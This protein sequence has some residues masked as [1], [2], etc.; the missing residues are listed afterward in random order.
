MNENDSQTGDGRCGAKTRAGTPCKRGAG[1]GTEHVGIGCCKLHG[2]STPNH[3]KSAQNQRALE[4]VQKYAIPIKTD[5][6]EAL[7]FELE[8]TAGWVAFLNEQVQGIE[9]IGHMRQLKGGGKDG[10]PEEVPH[11]WIQML[12]DERSHLLN[13]AK[14]C[15]AVGIEERRVK[16]AEQQGELLADFVRGLLEDL[17]IPITDEVRKVV[18]NRL[19]LIQGGRA[20]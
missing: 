1:A 20:A 19:T 10:I 18:R 13:V 8:R 6:H 4:A 9:K 5:P 2:G 3:I 12:K 11:I 14:T 15:I 7:I 17:K 16:L